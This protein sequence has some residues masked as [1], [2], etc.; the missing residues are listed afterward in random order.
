MAKMSQLLCGEEN[1]R[2]IFEFPEEVILAEERTTEDERQ[3]IFNGNL[4]ILSS[5]EPD[6]FLFSHCKSLIIIFKMR[7]KLR[8]YLFRNQYVVGMRPKSES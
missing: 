4:A 3:H 7:L 1:E 2:T 8:K 6:F 5:F